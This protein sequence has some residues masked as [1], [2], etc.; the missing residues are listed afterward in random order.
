MPEALKDTLFS[1][2][3]VHNFA[4]S[5]SSADPAFERST[6]LESVL[7]SGWGALEL[8]AR[9]RR[10]A[11][12]LK[13]LLPQDYTSALQILRR[14]A[15]YFPQSGF[16][17]MVFGDFTALYG[18]ED[19][20]ASLPA[21]AQFTCLGSAEYAVRP[22]IIR[23]QARMLA[24]MLEWAGSE[25]K[26]HRRLASE[27]CRPRLPWGISL[28]ALKADP[29]PILPILERLKNDPEDYVRRSLANNLNDITKDNPGVVFELLA[30]WKAQ[31]L[32]FFAEIAARALRSEIKN[33]DPAALALVGISHGALV[34]LSDLAVE[35]ARIPMEGEVSITFSLLSTAAEAQNLVID[36]IIHLVRAN[37]TLTPKV[38]KL[39]RRQLNPGERL[40]VSKRHSFRKITTRRYYPGTHAVEI[41]VNGVAVGRAEFEIGPGE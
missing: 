37:G 19:W 26:H 8:K 29:R 3:I 15:E 36:Y 35:P 10:M 30:R 1:R 22:F 7:D 5:I 21:L 14:A 4:A 24:Q 20:D 33:G 9:M 17:S 27:G 28:P 34:C 16:A 6:Y 31:D 12:C 18:L 11:L 38:F 32:P 40:S 41:Q 23:D 39:A 2:A 25:N 13:P